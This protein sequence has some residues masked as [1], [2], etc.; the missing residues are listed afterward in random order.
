MTQVTVSRER[1]SDIL[2]M[3]EIQRM[4]PSLS[5]ELTLQQAKMHGPALK[6]AGFTLLE[7]M[8]VLA[9]LGVMIS[10][11]SGSWQSVRAADQ[12]R[13]AA[14][15]MRGVMVAARMNALSTGQ[16]QYVGIDLYAEAMAS[17]ME[18]QSTYA[19]ST[20]SGTT[21]WQAFEGVNLLDSTS[22]GAAPASPETGQKT[23]SFTSR[24]TSVPGSILIKAV[25]GPA[26]IGKIIIFNNITGRVRI[27]DCSY[28]G[29][30]C[31]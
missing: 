22:N 11:A 23:I 25:S 16:T 31:Q 17:T 18:P 5:E 27:D 29:K 19:S 7:L 13:S 1:I 3:R 6:Q 28:T 21:L 12:V 2:K 24:G 30:S 14:E 10:V 26:S 4:T 20:W 9:I 15:K 8:V